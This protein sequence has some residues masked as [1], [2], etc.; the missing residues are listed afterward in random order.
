MLHYI[1]RA[2]TADDLNLAF[3]ITKEAMRDY[4]VATWGVWSE[5][6]QREWHRAGFAPGTHQIILVSGVPVGLVA[7]EVFVDRIALLKLYLRQ[8]VRGQGLGSAVLRGLLAMADEIH[9]P[10]Q[11]QVLRVNNGA[12]RF[13]LRHGFRGVGETRERLVM[14]RGA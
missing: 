11:L 5:P 10:V 12:Q 1:L 7:T 3:Q 14:R 9:L 6:E 13:Y 8:S 2:A 4:V